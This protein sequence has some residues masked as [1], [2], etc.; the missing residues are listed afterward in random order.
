MIFARVGRTG[1]LVAAALMVA[2]LAGL[3]VL[4]VRGVKLMGEGHTRRSFARAALIDEATNTYGLSKF[5]LLAWTAATIFGYLYL[6]VAR[7]FV[8]GVFTLADIPENLPGIILVAGSTSLLALGADVAHGSKGAGDEHPSLADFFTNGGV[9]APERLQ[10]FLDG[11]RRRRVSRLHGHARPGRDPDVTVNP[12]AVSVPH[13]TQLVRLRRR[14]VRAQSRPED[15]RCLGSARARDQC[16]WGRRA[17]DGRPVIDSS[18][19]VAPVATAHVLSGA[20]TWIGFNPQPG[21]PPVATR[22]D[23]LIALRYNVSILNRG[24][25]RLL[26]LSLF[27]LCRYSNVSILNRGC[28]RLLRGP[29]R[30]CDVPASFQSSTGVA[31]GC[32]RAISRGSGASWSFNPQP[33]LP[34]V[35]TVNLCVSEADSCFH[36]CWVT[37]LHGLFTH[38]KFREPHA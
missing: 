27:L 16:R 3:V 5:Q 1:P 6:S 21:L 32:Y 13:G 30:P 15:R 12:R 9:I 24:C 38:E 22:K 14:Q 8:Q 10:F 31:P 18:T 17:A 11:R 26:P 37:S 36:F 2:A 33:G 20:G 28:P 34:P 29:R 19:G 7:G 23:C 25:P 35:A 4:M